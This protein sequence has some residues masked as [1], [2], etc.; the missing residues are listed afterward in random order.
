MRKLRIRKNPEP[1]DTSDQRSQQELAAA[2]PD[3]LRDSVQKGL[4]E[5]PEEDR[6]HVY[7]RLLT[8]LNKVK[9]G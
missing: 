8:T 7:A 2:E 5:L 3:M 4:S 1:T 6:P 9:Q